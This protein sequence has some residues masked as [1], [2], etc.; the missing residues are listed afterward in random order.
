MA[1]VSQ[2]VFF[3]RVKELELGDIIPQLTAK[4]WTTQ[5]KAA[6]ATTY[7]PN[8]PDDKL[9]MEQFVKPLV[10]EEVVRIPALRRLWFEAYSA[11]MV[12]I[13]HRTMGSSDAGPRKLT[14]P[15]I[16]ARR[17]ETAAKVRGL[18]LE[19]ELE[20]SDELINAFASMVE[21]KAITCREIHLHRE[22]RLQKE[23]ALQLERHVAK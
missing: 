21:R 18:K 23:K 4:G 19:G 10:G 6:F 7:Q 9:L 1:S 8:Q 13:K 11:V 16:A 12:E 3:A 5:G 14:P 15:E 2:A 17:D 22:K 20:V